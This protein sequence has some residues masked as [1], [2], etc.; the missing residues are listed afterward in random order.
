ME[1]WKKNNS[2]LSY[3]IEE[4]YFV[5][6]L[7]LTFNF[8]AGHTYRIL[9][10]ELTLRKSEAQWSSINTRYLSKLS[11]EK[12]TLSLPLDVKDRFCYLRGECW[13]ILNVYTFQVHHVIKQR[14][15]FGL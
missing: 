10:S 6:S 4:N 5:S 11:L 8:Q 1:G 13:I 9:I 2:T 7:I 15:S 3:K 12:K 14:F